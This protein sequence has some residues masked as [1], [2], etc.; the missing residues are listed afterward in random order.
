MKE[1]IIAAVSMA[2]AFVSRDESKISAK[3]PRRAGKS[4]VIAMPMRKVH[5]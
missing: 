5:T 1:P 4:V 2:M 3:Y